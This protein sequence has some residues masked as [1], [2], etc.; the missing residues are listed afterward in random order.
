MKNISSC[1]TVKSIILGFMSL[2]AHV[3]YGQS[4]VLF[5]DQMETSNQVISADVQVL[6]DPGGK[7]TI[8][9]ILQMPPDQFSHTPNQSLSFGPTSSTF[10]I[11]FRLIVSDTSGIPLFLLIDNSL[12]DQVYL[13][14][15]RSGSSVGTKKSGNLEDFQ[16]RDFLLNRP[17]F[18]L[19]FS[20]ARDTVDYYLHARSAL[21][22]NVPLRLLSYRNL[23]E[24][25]HATT[26]IW[27]AFFGI[28]FFAFFY[29]LFLFAVVKERIYLYYI[30]YLLSASLFYVYLSAYAYLLLP[31][32]PV[33][34][35]SKLGYFI[36]ACS[37]LFSIW[38]IL[39]ILSIRQLGYVRM[40]RYLRW[41]PLLSFLGTGVSF[42]DRHLADGIIQGLSLLLF[43]LMIVL[44]TYIYFK[45]QSKT[46]GIIAAGW[47]TF[48]SLFVAFFVYLNVG[49]G[50]NIF[51]AHGNIIGLSCEFLIFAFALAHKI[52]TLKQD[53]ETKQQ[54]IIKF[55]E[56]KEQEQEQAKKILEQTVL[57]R[58]QSLREANQELETINEEMQQQNEEILMQKEF[59]GQTLQLLEQKNS[60]VE[61]SVQYARRIQNTM[62]PDLKEINHFFAEAGVFYLPRNTVSGD[63]Y[64]FRVLKSDPTKAYFC[65]SDCT[66]H[67]VPGALMSIM[68]MDLLSAIVSA[69]EDKMPNDVLFS[70]RQG[71]TRSLRQDVSD[72][73]DGMDVLLCLFDLKAKKAYFAGAMNKL[74][75][76]QFG[77][78]H[79]L[80]GDKFPIGGIYKENHLPY[81]LHEIDISS[82]T[83]F[84]FTS[85]GIKDQFGGPKG[86]K[87]MSKQLLSLFSDIQSLPA[88]QQSSRVRDRFF[89]W[90]GEFSQTDDVSLVI[91]KV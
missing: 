61:A 41:F 49:D 22:L 18:R 35:I 71:V 38:F 7:L 54:R 23:V 48:F 80:T 50:T 87:F 67:G 86:R 28:A 75:Y 73:R 2:L 63:F 24:Y 82:P 74:Y 81:Q 30:S 19:D 59:L 42:Y 47:I 40:A 72:N 79:T 25:I 51:L 65:L 66:G 76:H 39:D 17:I 77:Q 10:W 32:L 45:H 56:E 1:I 57:E 15:S 88:D 68:G 36:L 91:L 31:F 37:H 20:S 43:L 16:E 90:K 52:N 85:D 62:L 8:T 27:G 26:L 58:T 70:L 33:L 29:N 34:F 9:D 69:D 5:I 44:S 60:Q 89:A 4:H 21:P 53:N 46:A 78:L 6:E 55:L 3:A 83:T 64:W 13:Y 11:K 84:Y 14:E 12:I